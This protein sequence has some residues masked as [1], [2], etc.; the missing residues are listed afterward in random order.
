MD[1]LAFEFVQMNVDN[2]GN[3]VLLLKYGDTEI[4]GYLS[5]EQLNELHEVIEEILDPQRHLRLQLDKLKKFKRQVFTHY[6][7]A[8]DPEIKEQKLQLYIETKKMINELEQGV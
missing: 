4:S 5:L 8:T 2:Q 3:N 7:Q 1:Q 6:R